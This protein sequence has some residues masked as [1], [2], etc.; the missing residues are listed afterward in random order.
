MK[1]ILV[2]GASGNIGSALVRV[3]QQRGANFIAGVHDAAKLEV[4]KSGGIPAIAFDYKNPES[5]LNAFEGIDCAFIL[6]PLDANMVEYGEAAIAAAKQAGVSYIVKSSELGA[7][8]D[9]PLLALRTQ[10][11]IDES[12]KLSGI[13]YAILRPNFFMQN[14]A[15]QYAESIRKSSKFYLPQSGAEISFVDVRDIAAVAAELLMDPERFPNQAFD[16]TGPEALS[17]HAVAN[18]LSVA[19]NRPVQYAPVP[20]EIAIEGMRRNNVPEWNIAY[21]MS[22]HRHVKAGNMAATSN[23]IR[24]I[25]QTFPRD[26]FS[27]VHEYREIWM[28]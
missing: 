13:P 27:Y 6:L 25:T 28:R 16:L 14:F 15:S 3:L 1:K 21:L 5:M 20:D 23:N 19:I 12:I 2:T 17:N 7:D 4:L 22:L 8:K 9:S 18:Y 24:L 26:L 11:S 10:G